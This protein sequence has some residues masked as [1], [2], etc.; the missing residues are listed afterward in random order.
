MVILF[1]IQGRGTIFIAPIIQIRLIRIHRS[2]IIIRASRQ[3][4]LSFL[5]AN[6]VSFGLF[7]LV[8]IIPQYVAVSL[9]CVNRPA[10]A[11]IARFR[12]QAVSHFPIDGV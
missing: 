1:H 4:L 7:V 12:I 3:Q 6:N 11:H 10:R 8:R 9:K 5:V 2:I